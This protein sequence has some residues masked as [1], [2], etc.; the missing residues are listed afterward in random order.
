M[1][2]GGTELAQIEEDTAGRPHFARGGQ[3]QG[4]RWVDLEWWDSGQSEQAHRGVGWKA[5]AHV[6]PLT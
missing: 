6:P 3:I 2:L 4:P 5:A 1:L